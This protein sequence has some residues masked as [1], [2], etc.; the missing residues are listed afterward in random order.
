[1]NDSEN[2]PIELAALAQDAGMTPEQF[3]HDV[4]AST[5]V[6]GAMQIDSAAD[7]SDVAVWHFPEGNGWLQVI[8][9]RVDSGAHGVQS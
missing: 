3:V 1:M 9:R 2:R 7:D 8:V 5:A 6:V 4:A